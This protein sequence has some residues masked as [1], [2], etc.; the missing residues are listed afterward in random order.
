MASTGDDSLRPSVH[1]GDIGIPH[2]RSDSRV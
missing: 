1:W 2:N